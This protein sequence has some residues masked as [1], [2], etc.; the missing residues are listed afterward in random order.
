MSL[1][2]SE[3]K[4]DFKNIC[5]FQIHSVHDSSRILSQRRYP[6]TSRLSQNLKI[7]VSEVNGRNKRRKEVQWALTSTGRLTVYLEAGPEF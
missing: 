6:N 7:I 2:I 4:L 3:I 1:C 5:L